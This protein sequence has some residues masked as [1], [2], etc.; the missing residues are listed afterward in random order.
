MKFIFC[1]PFM[2]GHGTHPWAVCLHSEM[3]LEK[4]NVLCASVYQLAQASGLGMG[5]CVHF[6]QLLDPIWCS[7][8]Q[9]LPS[10]LSLRVCMVSCLEGLVFLMSFLSSGSDTLSASSSSGFFE[11]WGEGFAGDN[12]FSSLSAWCLAVT[13]CVCSRLHLYDSWARHVFKMKST[14]TTHLFQ[15]PLPNGYLTTVL[16]TSLSLL[17]L[18][19]PH[20]SSST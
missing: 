19:T 8:T 2:A 15:T 1:W 16:G 7:P 11:P 18:S 5:Q 9:A 17:L 13:V 14:E 12:L 6:S 3:P 20:P 10:S 4:T